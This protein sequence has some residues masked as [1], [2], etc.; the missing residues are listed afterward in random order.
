MSHVSL[1]FLINIVSSS[2]SRIIKFCPL[3]SSFFLQNRFVV[4][5]DQTTS[6]LNM[7]FADDAQSLKDFEKRY[8]KRAPV[9][10]CNGFD[11]DQNGQMDDCSTSDQSNSLFSS[12]GSHSG[13][14][15]FH[16][17]PPG[18]PNHPFVSIKPTFIRRRKLRVDQVAHLASKR[19]LLGTSQLE[20]SRGMAAPS[21]LTPCE[22]SK[23]SQSQMWILL[24]NRPVTGLLH[25]G[26]SRVK[27]LCGN[28]SGAV[29][30][31]VV[32]GSVEASGVGLYDDE[33]TE[34]YRLQRM[35]G[36]V[37]YYSESPV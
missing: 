15:R 17:T 32:I 10:P 1:T 9:A 20:S 12:P 34:R 13:F 8:R 21:R 27:E 24:S 28:G 26:T 35:R 37:S 30:K 25:G 29:Q 7:S 18:F 2:K 19:G 14:V 36:R 6:R 31:K 33:S 4:G 23:A 3:H 5:K 11:H 22:N 16:R